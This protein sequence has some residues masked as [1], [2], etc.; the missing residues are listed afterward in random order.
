MFFQTHKNVELLHAVCTAYHHNIDLLT[1]EKQFELRQEAVAWKDAW[2]KYENKI[3]IDQETQKFCAEILKKMKEEVDKRCEIYKYGVDLANYENI[4][5]K[6]LMD[7]LI[8]I[9]KFDP[10]EL[11][12]LIEWWLFE[13]V[14]KVITFQNGE[15]MNVEEADDLVRFFVIIYTTT[16]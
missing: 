10:I 3:A 15:S 4:Y 2:L 13:S 16:D 1:A 8:R 7:C 9:L 6:C 5:F 12:D 14:D 11:K